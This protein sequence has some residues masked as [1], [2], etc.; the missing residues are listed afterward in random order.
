MGDKV[1]ELVCLYRSFEG[2]IDNNFDVEKTV[3]GIK[4]GHR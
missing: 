4:D 3:S 1:L 2:D